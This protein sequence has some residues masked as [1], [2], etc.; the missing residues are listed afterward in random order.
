MERRPSRRRRRTISKRRALSHQS[1]DQID[2]EQLA[3]QVRLPD[4]LTGGRALREHRLQ[5]PP[6]RV[7]EAPNGRADRVRASDY[8]P[9][10]GCVHAALGQ[11]PRAGPARFGGQSDQQVLDT[12][13]LV[14]QVLGFLLGR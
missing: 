11:R 8:C 9:Q 6:C 1:L 12:E 3:Q 4:P 10:L 14:P 7:V 13:P 5:D 2:P